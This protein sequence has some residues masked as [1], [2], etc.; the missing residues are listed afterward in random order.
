MGAFCRI[1]MLPSELKADPWA[2][3]VTYGPGSALLNSSVGIAA[4]AIGATGKIGEDLS[5]K[6]TPRGLDSGSKGEAHGTSCH[7]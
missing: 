1:K 3:L 4:D 5:G 2:E 7:K 6:S